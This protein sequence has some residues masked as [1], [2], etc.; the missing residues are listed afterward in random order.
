MTGYGKGE[1][2][3]ENRKYIVEVKSVN[4]KYLEY[5][6]KLPKSLSIFE[7]NIRK[8]ISTYITRGKIEVSVRF[9]NFSEIAVV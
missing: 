7:D 9:E 8:L 4:H 5:S 3:G 2:I 6:F 1:F